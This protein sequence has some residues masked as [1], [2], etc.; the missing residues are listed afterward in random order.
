[1]IEDVLTKQEI[2]KYL[3]EINKKL[4]VLNEKGE[5]IICGGAS[6]ALVYNARDSTHDIDAYFK[7]QTTIRQIISEIS[8]ENNLHEDWM[9][10]GA[11]GFMTEQMQH[12]VIR[13][14]SNLTVRSIDA[15]SLLAMKLVSARIN[16][17]N[18]KA[19]ALKLIQHLQVQSKEEL[20]VMVEKYAPSAN[21]LPKA[22]YF[23]EL[24]YEEYQH[25]LEKAKKP[26][27]KRSR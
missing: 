27:P 11:K 19:D 13:E 4:S 24:C 2:E 22:Q 14:Y 7:P 6:M 5:I 8:Q 26:K 12:T 25:S 3:G 20:F 18:D 21:R 10:D 9:N 23:I 15:E 17:A 16:Y 1:M